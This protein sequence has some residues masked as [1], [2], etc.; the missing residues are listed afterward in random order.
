MQQVANGA[1]VALLGGLYFVAQPAIGDGGA[2]T[3]C[4]LGSVI[5]LLA[6]AILLARMSRITARVAA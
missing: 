2:F 6:S 1:G 5:A 4:L 3:V